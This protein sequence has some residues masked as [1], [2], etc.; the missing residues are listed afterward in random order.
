MPTPVI[1]IYL[2]K[3]RKKKENKFPVKLRVYHD[4]STRQYSTGISLSEPEFEKSY[5]CIKP[6]ETHNKNLKINLAGIEA[7][8]NEIVRELKI[9]TFKKFEKKLLRPKGSAINI[10]YHYS[11]I[12]LEL[13]KQERFSTASNYELSLK[14]LQ[15]FEIAKGRSGKLIFQDISVNFLNEYEKW[16]L[17]NFKSI[18]TVGIYLRP[19]KAI[20]NSAILAGEI[21][22]EIYP[23]GKRKYQIPSGQSVKKALSKEDLKKMYEYPLLDLP[24]LAKARDFWFFSY[25][26]NGMN[27][28]DIANLQY[29]VF[30]AESFYFIRNKTKNTSK[31]NQKKIKVILSPFAKGVIKN[32]GNLKTNS[33]IYVFPILKPEI[34]EKEK[35][36]LVQAFTRFVNQHIKTLA[37]IIGI[38]ENISTYWARHTF[39]TVAVNEGASLEFVQESLGHN[40]LNTTKTYFAGFN[41]SIKIEISKK[42]L[43]F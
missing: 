42:L 35:I 3:R 6:K 23:F 8:A 16:M 43:Q 39:S 38:D 24:L 19:L 12:I 36:R 41:D 4:Y 11:E 2:D 14:S 29:E 15:S 21:S 31:T 37:K 27:I 40:S 18:T 5:L 9:F 25:V 1:S 30:S 10:N 7:N 13:K 34:N 33:H 32:Y 28:R 17:N 22:I 20:F 26:C